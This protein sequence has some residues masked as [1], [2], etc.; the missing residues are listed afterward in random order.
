MA[1]LQFAGAAGRVTGS[2]YILEA[3]GLRILVEWGLYQEREFKSRLARTEF[4]ISSASALLPPGFPGADC[5]RL[6]PINSYNAK[7]LARPNS[8][9]SH[10]TC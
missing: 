6:E 10:C 4:S 3:G 2:Q 8:S 9:S 1:T 7:A 5:N